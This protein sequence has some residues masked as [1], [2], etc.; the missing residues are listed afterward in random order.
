KN[1]SIE[2]KGG[3]ETR[4]DGYKISLEGSAPSDFETVDLTEQVT[5]SLAEWDTIVKG[6]ESQV[7]EP[8][9]GTVVTVEDMDE[10]S[11]LQPQ[12]STDSGNSPRAEAQPLELTFDPQTQTIDDYARII[13]NAG[14][15]MKEARAEYLREFEHLRFQV[16]GFWHPEAS[17]PPVG[18]NSAPTDV[19]PLPPVSPNSSF[20]V[21]QN[22]VEELTAIQL[23]AVFNFISNNET[24]YMPPKL[25]QLNQMSLE[26]RVS[27]LSILNS[28]EL[29]KRVSDNATKLI[30]QFANWST[31]VPDGLLSYTSLTAWSQEMVHALTAISV[32]RDIIQ[33]GIF[34]CLASEDHRVKLQSGLDRCDVSM[35]RI[36][37]ILA[38]ASGISA[39]LVRY[40]RTIETAQLMIMAALPEGELEAHSFLSDVR[41]APP[42]DIPQDIA[43]F[44]QNLQWWRDNYMHALDHSQT[45]RFVDQA[46]QQVAQYE[47]SQQ[48]ST[49]SSQQSAGSSQQ[50]ASTAKFKSGGF[51]T[52]Q[53]SPQRTFPS[54]GSSHSTPISGG[55]IS[56]PSREDGPR[57][58]GISAFLVRYL[59]TIETAQLMIMAALPEGELE[60]HSFLSD[61]RQA[62]PG[63]I[64]QDI[65]VFTQNLQWWRD[66]Y[67]HALD[68]SQTKRF[69][70]QAVQQVAQYER[71]Q[72]Q[73]TSSSQQSAGSSQQTA[74]TAK[75]KSGGFQTQQQSPQRTFPSKGSS[76]STP[77]SGGRTSAPSRED[78]R[79]SI[80]SPGSRKRSHDRSGGRAVEERDA[81]RSR[82]DEQIAASEE[83]RRRQERPIPSPPPQDRPSSIQPPC[84]FCAH[85]DHYSA[86]CHYY[87]RLSERANMLRELVLCSNCL[88]QHY[89][90]CSRL[91]RCLICAQ[92]GHHQAICVLNRHAIVDITIP[93]VRFYEDVGRDTYVPGPREARERQRLLSSSSRE[94]APQP[95]PPS[96][97][98]SRGGR[99]SRRSRPY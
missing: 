86:E 5:Q 9:S 30:Q 64:P 72:Q 56:A 20:F 81:R 63:D 79:G 50:T 41:Q 33:E 27:V 19:F 55:R 24:E 3:D 89:G 52:Q 84:V 36:H 49:S 34:P 65:A 44:T 25:T 29:L 97:S 71:S 26:T 40:L 60:A 76:H 45:K 85:T 69:V 47:R 10:S 70:D 8:A 11:S 87:K 94:A 31:V 82:Y 88:K 15:A 77:I 7:Q 62:P 13:R 57:A 4:L 75:F 38:R 51:Q 83:R 21:N 66:N 90:E 14:K 6:S 92:R 67:M 23:R 93:A 99:G 96:R 39:F 78:G 61:V 43:V 22:T 28:L 80:V 73:S 1:S 53:Q 58:S 42:G 74:S 37:S 17:Q 2:G 59:R 35:T 54:K 98:L 95:R 16:E 46:V 91:E 18:R 32:N 12:L 68:H 48:Q